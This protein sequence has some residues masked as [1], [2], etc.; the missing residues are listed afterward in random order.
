MMATCA[1]MHLTSMEVL[2]TEIAVV[3]RKKEGVWV[4]NEH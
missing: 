3:F 1:E 2:W 4:K